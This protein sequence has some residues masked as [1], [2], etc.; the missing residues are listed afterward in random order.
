MVLRQADWSLRF[1]P[2]AAATRRHVHLARLVIANI[3]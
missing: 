1:Y 3:G 2:E